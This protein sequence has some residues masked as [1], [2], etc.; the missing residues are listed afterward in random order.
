MTPHPSDPR[1]SLP[2]Q[3]APQWRKCDEFC[4]APFKVAA[5]LKMISAGES[6][7]GFVFDFDNMEVRAYSFGPT[8]T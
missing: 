8:S 3:K 6:F 4:Y 7:V 1:A 5:R 2:R